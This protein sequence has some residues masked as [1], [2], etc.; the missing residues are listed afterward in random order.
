MSD[1]S[2]ER[3]NILKKMANLSQ[4]IEYNRSRIESDKN[5]IKEWEIDMVVKQKEID[6]YE[7]ELMY[8]MDQLKQEFH[9]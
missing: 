1:Y 2:A 3:H 5:A 9:E 4:K 7:I 8:L 6:D